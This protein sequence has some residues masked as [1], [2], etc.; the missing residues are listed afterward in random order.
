M[1]IKKIKFTAQ[2]IQ[3]QTDSKVQTNN[4]NGSNE[5]KAQPQSVVD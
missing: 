3:Y 4:T 2:I 1:I 5:V